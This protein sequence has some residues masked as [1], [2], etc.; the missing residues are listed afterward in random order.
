MTY[1][2]IHAHKGKKPSGEVVE[3]FQ[4]SSIMSMIEEH[5]QEFADFE[6]QIVEAKKNLNKP[7]VTT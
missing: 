1:F 7:K 6:R 4:V 5:P 2:T 3:V